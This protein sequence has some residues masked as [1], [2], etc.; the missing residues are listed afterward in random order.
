MS[1]SSSPNPTANGHPSRRARRGP[2]ARRTQERERTL[3]TSSVQD[4]IRLLIAEEHE[5]KSSRGLLQ[6]ALRRVDEETRRADAA[7]L[8]AYD[9]TQRFRVLAAELLTAQGEAARTREQLGMYK[10]Q[11]DAAQREIERAEAVIRVVEREREAAEQEAARARTA[12]RR[13][14][15]ETMIE[16]AREEGRRMG[17]EEGLRRG[18]D[19]V[20][21]SDDLESL[22]EGTMPRTRPRSE[23]LSSVV[24]GLSALDLVALPNPGRERGST[25][26]VIREDIRS[27]SPSIRPGPSRETLT[28]GPGPAHLV[29][30]QS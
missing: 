11:L 27:P 24:T 6:T 10:V 12:A 14:G 28:D 8:R 3:S 17:F 19:V 18:R 22:V 5:S 29:C 15:E 4:L 30:F 2:S 7:D 21:G 1:S 20:G 13:M 23:S 9:A 26:S 16:R 25:L